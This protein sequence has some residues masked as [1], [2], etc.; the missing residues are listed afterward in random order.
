MIATTSTKNYR[1]LAKKM[2]TK[3]KSFLE[4][5]RKKVPKLRNKGKHGNSIPATPYA[6]VS[7]CLTNFIY[8]EL[9]LIK[10]SIYA[11]PFEREDDRIYETLDW[12]RE[13]D[14][15]SNNTYL[16]L[17][18]FH[19]YK[20]IDKTNKTTDQSLDYDEMQ[21]YV[22]KSLKK[23]DDESKLAFD[24]FF[25]C[26]PNNK[27][28]DLLKTAVI[29]HKFGVLYTKK[30]PDKF[31]LI[32][33]AAL[34]NAARIRSYVMF[35]NST[36]R[37]RELGFL[38]QTLAKANHN[39][40][41]VA[42]ADK[43]AKKVTVMRNKVRKVVES[44]KQI[45]ENLDKNTLRKCEEEKIITLRNIQHFVTHEYLKIMTNLS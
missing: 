6:P 26:Q 10:E 38:I 9:D 25:L 4:K 24:L 44:V 8:E 22:P 33:A 20:E 42:A 41:L 1:H 35:E 28:K 27:E 7:N 13:A 11:A 45:P 29:F 3:K 34:L 43:V 31:D 17:D 18:A 36:R 12:S 19:T 40:D 30:S 16:T 15:E 2:S 37:L 32:R 14:I 21:F 23:K 5:L 39:E